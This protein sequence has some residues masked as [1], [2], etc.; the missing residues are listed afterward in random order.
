MR[1]WCQ[2]SKPSFFK[3]FEKCAKVNV[4]MKVMTSC[5]KCIYSP[6][7]GVCSSYLL[8]GSRCCYVVYLM[9]QKSEL[10]IGVNL[11]LCHI[12]KDYSKS[13]LRSLLSI[14]Y[15]RHWD[16]PAKNR[17]FYLFQKLKFWRQSQKFSIASVEITKISKIPFCQV[18]QEKPQE[19]C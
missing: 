15:L 13:S 14:T 6:K 9:M 10:E 17:F 4:V 16:P 3:V 12:I 1:C 7:D 18:N 8:V 11:L 19:L 2:I 5:W